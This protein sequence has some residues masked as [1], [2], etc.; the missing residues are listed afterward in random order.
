[1]TDLYKMTVEQAFQSIANMVR[2]RRKDDSSYL[3]D[4]AEVV[5]AVSALLHHDDERESELKELRARRVAAVDQYLTETREQSD[6]SPA[7]EIRRLRVQLENAD[8]YVT[9][10]LRE[11]EVN[12]QAVVRLCEILAPNGGTDGMT[13]AETAAQAARHLVDRKESALS[14]V[15]HVMRVEAGRWC[16]NERTSTA[17]D[18]SNMLVHLADELERS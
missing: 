18:I 17:Q 16:V 13:W 9:A 4:P 12:R 6:W 10:A 14:R 1:M 7:R 5:A 2:S 8:K 15:A 3:S 11:N